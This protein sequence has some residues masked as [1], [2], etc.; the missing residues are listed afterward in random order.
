MINSAIL[1]VIAG[2]RIVS[3]TPGVPE[4][5]STTA[6]NSSSSVASFNLSLPGSGVSG[7]FYVALV[8]SRNG[9]TMGGTSWTGAGT[10]AFADFNQRIEIFTKLK[11]VEEASV[12]ITSVGGAQRIDA[13]IFAF[14]YTGG[15]V[16]YV[17]QF[18]TTTG[19]STTV[20]QTIV[21][22]TQGL[23][24]TAVTNVYRTTTGGVNTAMACT[25]SIN[26][27]AATSV[28]GNAAWETAW[29]TT[30]TNDGPRIRATTLKSAGSAGTSYNPIIYTCSATAPSAPALAACTFNLTCGL[31]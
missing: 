29:T 26:G 22:A 24:V 31:P 11:T 9:A 15:V 23:V 21:L 1:S 30:T 16:P 3:T 28:I 14:T 13:V 7:L 6:R 19:A 25:V 8:T 2:A 5:H 18:T 27:G 10:S 4:W 12:T 17:S 20:G